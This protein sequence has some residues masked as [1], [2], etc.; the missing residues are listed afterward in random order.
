MFFALRHRFA[1]CGFVSIMS[2]G[3]LAIPGGPAVAQTIAPA[4]SDLESFSAERPAIERMV[5][6]GIMRGASG[7]KFAPNSPLTRGD[8]VIALQKMFQLPP[9][10]QPVVLTDVSPD[11]PLFS[12][13][14][15]AMPYLGRQLLCPG[16]ALG[17]N[18]VPDH[19]IT[20]GEQTLALARL[21]VA[22]KKLQPASAAEAATA[23]AG[24]KDAGSVPRL[25]APYF[26]AA[27]ESGLLTVNPDK[28]LQLATE[29]TRVNAATA[30][31][32]VQQKFAIP[33]VK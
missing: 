6:Q 31:D 30:L 3:G 19:P 11:D 18:F 1:I 25:A 4:F 13:T 5:T 12:A 10:D 26:A 7:T 22:R 23:L 15:A 14:Q 2:F 20:L 29:Q 24:I 16:C 8:F 28:T 21:L 33:A 17:T 32:A 27:I 9:P